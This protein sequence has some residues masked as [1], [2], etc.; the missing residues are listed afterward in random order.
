[1]RENRTYQLTD[2]PRGIKKKAEP[3]VKPSVGQK[4]QTKKQTSS[5]R[6]KLQLKRRAPRGRAERRAGACHLVYGP[7]VPTIGSTLVNPW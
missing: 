6:I 2:L 3:G 4:K 1:M 5:K 7:Q